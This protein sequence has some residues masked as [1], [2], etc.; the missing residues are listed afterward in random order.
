M[1]KDFSQ[2]PGPVTEGDVYPDISI[3]DVDIVP[4]DMDEDDA[5]EEDFYD[6]LGEGGPRGKARR[7]ARRAN[8]GTRRSGKGKGPGVINRVHN[9]KEK[10]E[11]A[12]RVSISAPEGTPPARIAAAAETAAIAKKVGLNLPGVALDAAQISPVIVSGGYMN[13]K[14]TEAKLPGSIIKAQF[15]EWN[16][17]VATPAKTYQASPSS[18]VATLTIGGDATNGPEGVTVTVY[19]P[20]I[21]ISLTASDYTRQKGA[22]ITITITGT[23]EAGNALTSDTFSIIRSGSG[24]TEIQFIP[25]V[26]VRERLRPKL[27]KVYF[28]DS[29]PVNFVIVAT[30]VVTGE[31]LQATLPGVNSDDVR[32]W[33]EAFGLTT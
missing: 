2:F 17:S 18:G 22:E 4:V 10:L 5:D 27:A 12:S 16:R 11:K 23:D 1:T 30:S 8:R 26:R 19:F 21:F 31:L 25:Y 24:P 29:S 15:M 20:I 13:S 14:P 7:E 28:A 6:D 9:L 3:G 32:K 33:G